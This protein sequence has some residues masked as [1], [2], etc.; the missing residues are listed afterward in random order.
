MKKKSMLII[1]FFFLLM[2]CAQR[3]NLLL[4]NSYEH[5]VIVHS[6]YKF[7]NNFIQRSDRFYPGMV[8]AVAAR[9]SM[10]SNII[11]MRIETLEGVLLE[12]YQAEHIDLLRK[13]YKSKDRQER[14]VFTEKGLFI[15]TKEI[16]ERFNTID[17]VLN[18]FRSDEA[19]M[20]LQILLEEYLKNE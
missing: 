16:R 8:F 20:D 15:R 17:E 5:D 2:S 19:V 6:F 1:I 12:D 18:Y 4:I 9:S 11:A 13:A 14:W 7:G 10:Y 3:N